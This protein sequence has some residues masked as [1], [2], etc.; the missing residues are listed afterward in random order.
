M[1]EFT[2]EIKVNASY[3]YRDEPADPR[4]AHGAELVLIL[5]GPLGA[6]AAKIMTGWMAAPLVDRFVPGREQERRHKPGVDGGLTDIYPSGA[7]VG[8]HSYL[9]R[10][11]LEEG[12]PCDWLET[13]ACYCGVSYSRADRTLERLVIGGS[14]AAFEDLETLYE[15]WIAE[16]PVI[17]EASAHMTGVPEPFERCGYRIEPLLDRHGTFNPVTGN[18]RIGKDGTHTHFPARLYEALTDDGAF[19]NV[20]SRLFYLPDEPRRPTGFEAL[21]EQYGGLIAT[22]ANAKPVEPRLEVRKMEAY[23]QVSRE[24]LDEAATLFRTPTPEERAE[25][26]ARHAAYRARKQA[27]HAEAV[28]EWEQLRER[29]AGSPAVVAV[30]DIHRPDDEGRLECAHLTFGYESDAEDW[31]CSTYTAIKEATP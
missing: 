14:D 12:G 6:I 15:S 1:T 25:A 22:A 29:Y 23:V 30:L 2:R 28:T 9:P 17:I 8:C 21:A 16:R 4:G 19:L 5:R 27:E 26:E 10:E 31:P 7:Y 24:Q 11:G 20:A 18:L 13:A 3:D